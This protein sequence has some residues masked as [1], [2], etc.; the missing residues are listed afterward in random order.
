MCKEIALRGKREL[1]RDKLFCI[2]VIRGHLTS[3][4]HNGS[5]DNVHGFREI[6]RMNCIFVSLSLV[7][8]HSRYSIGYL[9]STAIPQSSTTTDTTS[10]TL[11]T[12]GNRRV[13]VMPAKNKTAE[14][15][16]VRS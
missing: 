9:T 15:I 10:D 5:I 8:A 12:S 1:L 2:S 3:E 6:S 13:D 11:R 7:S 4:S 14:N 16:T